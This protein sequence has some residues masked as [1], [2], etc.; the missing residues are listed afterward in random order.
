MNRRV[1]WLGSAGVLGL[2]LAAGV[3]IVARLTAAAG[4]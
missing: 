3:L 1:C 4:P 2:A